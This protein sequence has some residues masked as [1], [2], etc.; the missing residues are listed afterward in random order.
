MQ[1]STNLN[2]TSSTNEK[3][4]T[5]EVQYYLRRHSSRKG[6][7][8][9][10]VSVNRKRNKKAFSTGV[11]C[12]PKLWDKSR[13]IIKGPQHEAENILLL[14]IKKALFEIFFEFEKRDLP[15]T[16]DDV[17]KTFVT[18]QQ[19]SSL[20]SIA[21]RWLG[22]MKAEVGQTISASTFRTYAP[23]IKHLTTFLRSID[24]QDIH[25][26]NFT[27]NI[28]D[29]FATWLKK[30]GMQHNSAM[31]VV[32]QVSTIQ[33]WAYRKKLIKHKP[34]EGYGY[35]V[36]GPAVPQFL[37]PEQV[38]RLGTY[39]FFSP[40]LQRVADAMVLQSWTG[41]DYAD[42]AELDWQKHTFRDA[43]GTT[44][45]QKKRKKA[46]INSE[47]QVMNVPLMPEAWRI[48]RK[49]KMKVPLWNEE[50]GKVMS[51]DKYNKYLKEVAAIL[52]ISIKLTTKT[53]RKTYINMMFE[54][55]LPLEDITDMVGHND[56]RITRSTYLKFSTKRVRTSIERVFG[57]DWLEA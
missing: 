21:E 20:L 57:T 38:E 49:Y 54:R 40:T 55:G 52:G 14:N 44:W 32:L 41:M 45:I 15:F 18:G 22:A 19:G 30:G 28:A 11:H 50:R 37:L 34:L 16:A 26:E 42:M 7:I 8:Y 35:N 51:Y 4:Y 56:T 13:K 53:G 23:R 6:T 9:C 46:R 47:R 12:P 39:R 36:K 3:K 33:K 27:D 1:H 25:P 31:R 48:F 5:F 2:S 10:H 43:K 29:D 17:H 24:R